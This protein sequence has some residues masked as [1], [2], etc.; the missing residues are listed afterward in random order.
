MNI[1]YTDETIINSKIKQNRFWYF[2]NSNMLKKKIKIPKNVSV[3]GALGDDE[4]F[5]YQL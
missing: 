5:C 2:S 4:F 1:I 3:L